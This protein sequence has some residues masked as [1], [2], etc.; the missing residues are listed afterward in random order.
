MSIQEE[1]LAEIRKTNRLLALLVAG[2]QG[3]ELPDL[4]CPKCGCADP[5]HLKVSA[6][7][8][9]GQRVTCAACAHTWKEETNG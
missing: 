1:I 3:E 4:S 5:E 9:E 2:V 6:A 8:G 7:F